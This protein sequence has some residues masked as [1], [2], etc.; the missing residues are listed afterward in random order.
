[1]MEKKAQITVQMA[2][3]IEQLEMAQQM[4]LGDD[5]KACLLL[6]QAASREIKSVAYRITPILKGANQ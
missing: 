6:L 1:M 3:I 5:E 4:W 2:Q